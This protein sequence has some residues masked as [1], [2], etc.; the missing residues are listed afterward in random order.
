MTITINELKTA[1]CY[2]TLNRKHVI[3]VGETWMHGSYGVVTIDRIWRIN[4]GA[5]STKVMFTDMG[6]TQRIASAIDMGAGRW[7]VHANLLFKIA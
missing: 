4:N 5:F 6:G 3:K 2:D 7:Q 1:T